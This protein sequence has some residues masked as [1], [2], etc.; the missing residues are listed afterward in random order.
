M[1]HKV[2]CAALAVL[3]AAAACQGIV[4]V[5]PVVY[6][7]SLSILSVVFNMFIAFS[8]WFAVQG[9]AGGKILGRP[10]HSI[11]G[12]LIPAAGRLAL[13]LFFVVSFS[14]VLSPVTISE[15]AL[16]SALTALFTALLL[17]LSN[18]RAIRNSERRLRP[19][20]VIAAFSIL[21][22]V[23]CF[24]A[25][26]E[27]LEVAAYQKE[28]KAKHQGA[29][30]VV[31]RISEKALAPSMAARAYK[32]EAAPSGMEYET[33][34]KSGEAVL[35]LWLNPA[36]E[37]ACTL[38]VRSES[39]SQS[40]TYAP[41]K[42]CVLETEEGFERVFCPIRVAPSD[43]VVGGLVELDAGGSCEGSMKARVLPD[44]FEVA[45]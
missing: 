35:A 7:A 37:E 19:V 33:E 18:F 12:F 24:L 14:V 43:I 44:R 31:S 6:V 16:V 5:P 36:S 29:L 42:T 1:R 30:P 20:A 27:S 41:D 3:L 34:S 28:S 45:G 32:D 13:A 17:F 22:F 38:T 2:S 23:L 11:L 10:L 4:V 15:M 40:L 26:R 39:S 9:V 25:V 21:V 8:F